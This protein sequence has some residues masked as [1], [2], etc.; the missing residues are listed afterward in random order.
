VRLYD[1]EPFGTG[2]IHC[3]LTG[4]N[5]LIGQFKIP[6]HMVRDK[7]TAP[8]WANLYGAPLS[9]KDQHALLMN[10]YGEQYGSHYRGRI[11]YSITTGYSR[12]P[13]I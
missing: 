12:D 3:L 13:K 1:W 7:I 11:M 9:G 10:L 4:S 8:R 6:F 5:I 2:L